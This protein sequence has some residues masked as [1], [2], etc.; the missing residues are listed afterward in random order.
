MASFRDLLRDTK[1][2]IREVDTAGAETEIARPETVVLDVREPDEYEQGALPRAVHIPRG[3]LESQIEGKIPDHDAHIVV[4]C[5]GGTRSAFAADTLT[6]LGYSDVASMAGGFNKWKDEGRQW[7]PPV[8]LSADQRNRYQRHILLPEVDVAGQAKLLESKMLCIGAGGLGSPAALY[9]AAAG[10]GTIGIIDMDV[11]DASNLQRQILH[12]MDRIG[13]RKVDSAKKT[14]TSLNPDVNVV[15]YDVR[16][17]ADNILD[18]FAGYDLIIDGTDNFPTR[19]LV[20]DAS[21]KLDIPVVHG[22]IFRF[23]GQAS[24]YLPHDGPCYRCQVPEPPPAEL[25]PSCSEAGVLGVLPGIIGSIQAM[26]AIKLILGIGDPLVGR[27]LAYDA[28]EES[29]RTFKVNRDPECAACSIPKEQ[30]VIAE[31]D[32]LCMPHPIAPPPGS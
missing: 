23:E 2:R 17:G 32:E 6:Q 7:K 24:V 4:Y 31:Y 28:L 16:L 8:S 21:L 27:L 5:A 1:A 26:E 22:S 12:N 19:Y 20:N 11:V 18:I 25:A 9:L 3:H 30:L 13:E 15:T 10:V 29:F 14:L